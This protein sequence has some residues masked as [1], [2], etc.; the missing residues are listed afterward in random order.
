M[1]ILN[2]LSDFWIKASIETKI[3]FENFLFPEGLYYEK[4]GIFRTPVIASIIQYLQE[5]DT[6]FS[7]LYNNSNI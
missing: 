3:K 4:N 6:D 7:K 1:D 2:N 5:K